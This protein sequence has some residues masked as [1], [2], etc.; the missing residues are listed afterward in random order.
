MERLKPDDVVARF[1]Q[2]LD[3][4][5]AAHLENV[6][7]RDLKPENV[8]WCETGSELVIAD[9]GIAHFEEDEIYTAVE[10]RVADRMANFRYSAPEQRVRGQKVDHRADI[11]SLG[12]LLNELFTGTVPQGAGYGRIGGVYSDHAYLDEIVEH[13]IQ[14]DPANRP[15]SIDV[16]KRALIGSKNRFVALQ[17]YDEVS[18]QVVNA[19]QPPVFPPISI[20]GVDY[21][22]G[23]L[24]LALS[25][26]PPRRWSELFCNPQ[27]NYSS[28]Q[29][30]GPEA[31]RFNED[32]VFIG[33]RA[34][35]SLV[36]QLVNFAK[37]YAEMA[38]RIYSEEVVAQALEEEQRQRVLLQK[39]TASAAFRKDLLSRVK[40]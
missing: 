28:I 30:Y 36:Q 27:G 37:Q 24:V 40:L 22:E 29:G 26:K 19:S 34:D 6:W 9:F 25:R 17:K 35:A 23:A 3:G 4:V 31:F 8:L 38:N 7:H 13:M 10:T 21:L 33:V 16:I 2:V 12:L 18:R 32:K 14:Q 11:F 5:E 15:S 1:C 39:A 20:V